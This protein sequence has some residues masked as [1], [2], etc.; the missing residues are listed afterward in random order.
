MHYMDGGIESE[1]LKE[2]SATYRQT[3]DKGLYGL[4]IPQLNELLQFKACAA[5]R[6]T[7]T[8]A[9]RI[10]RLDFNATATETLAKTAFQYLCQSM[11]LQTAEVC[12]GLFEL[13]WPSLYYILRN[14]KADAQTL[15]GI[16]PIKFCQVKQPEFNWSVKVDAGKG[17]LMAAKVKPPPGANSSDDL[18]IL[19]LTDIHYDPEYKVG[20]LAFCKEPLCCRSKSSGNESS[21]ETTKAGYWSDYNNCDAPLHMIENALD[22]IREKHKDIDYIYLSGDLVPH[23]VWSTAPES[24]KVI[25]TNISELIRRKFGNLPVYPVVGNHEEHP[26]NV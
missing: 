24:N 14:S 15:C 20:S 5:C 25:I 10:L 4:K 9:E 8:I 19:Q 18:T 21:D 16:L 11:N 7:A 22:H 23:N 12:K 1:K 13:N 6:I 17:A 3:D 26:V 2:L